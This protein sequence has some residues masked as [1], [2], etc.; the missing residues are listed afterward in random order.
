M[1]STYSARRDQQF[2]LSAFLGKKFRDRGLL[3]KS[4]ENLAVDSNVD[5]DYIQSISSTISV[6][7]RGKEEGEI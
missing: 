1:D 7:K 5:S 6:R 2:S 4:R 3:R